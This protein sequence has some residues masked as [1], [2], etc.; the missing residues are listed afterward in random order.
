MGASEVRP[1]VLD[2]STLSRREV[3]AVRLS[4]L[5]FGASRGDVA[6]PSETALCRRPTAGPSPG[7]DAPDRFDMVLCRR[8]VSAGAS[9]APA[10]P[11]ETALR[12][13]SKLG[14]MTGDSGRSA[15][16]G[17]A[18]RLRACDDVPE[19]MLV[20][21]DAHVASSPAMTLLPALDDMNDD[22][23]AGSA[24]L[25]KTGEV[26]A[27][28]ERSTAGRDELASL[29]RDDGRSGCSEA[30]RRRREDAMLDD[31]ESCDDA[32]AMTAAWS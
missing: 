27:L 8:L 25:P 20:R 7:P 24:G 29:F 3:D 22:A 13:R 9:S 16:T 21:R 6:V 31:R 30:V 19:S 10:E 18:L 26:C 28:G 17:V 14:V 1:D 2:G 32:R 15:D 4:R 11:I 12:R 5:I 23:V